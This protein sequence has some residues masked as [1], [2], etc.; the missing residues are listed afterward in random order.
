MVSHNPLILIQPCWTSGFYCPG[1]V[2]TLETY[3]QKLESCTKIS[4]AQSFTFFKKDN[5]N[6]IYFFQRFASTLLLNINCVWMTVKNSVLLDRSFQVS[7]Q[8]CEDNNTGRARQIVKG[9]PVKISKMP[10]KENCI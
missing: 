5:Y 1:V 9:K 3:F 2:S 7:K 6:H 4:H 8:G 10:E